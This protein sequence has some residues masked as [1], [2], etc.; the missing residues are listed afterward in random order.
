MSRRIETDTIDPFCKSL[1]SFASFVLFVLLHAQ[2]M[3]GAS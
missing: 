2:A 1:L 3:L